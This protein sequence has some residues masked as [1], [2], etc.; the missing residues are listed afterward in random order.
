MKE[1]GVSEARTRL[2][3]LL[4]QVAA[5]AEFTITRRGHAIARL[6]PAAA[7]RE[8]EIRHAVQEM[9]RFPA[10]RRLGGGGWRALRDA[11]RKW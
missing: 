8:D 2:S 5:G 7:S 3:E 1:I 9:A 4:E 11:N 6:V 10:G